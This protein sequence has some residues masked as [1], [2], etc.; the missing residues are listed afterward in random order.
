MH[1]IPSRDP[2]LH[3]GTIRNLN[4]V[5]AGGV[6]RGDRLADRVAAIGGSWGFIIAFGIALVVWTVANSLLLGRAAFDVYPYIFLNLVLS[7]LAAIQAPIIMMSQNRAAARDRAAAQLDYDINCK[8]EHEI[9]AIHERM[10]R[11]ITGLHLKL[12]A[13]LHHYGID[14]ETIDATQP[15]A[16]IGVHFSGDPA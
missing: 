2:A 12:N 10:D 8:A 6:S 13:V 9:L 11:E 15:A 1:L 7:M 5:H 4:D 14:P 16:P 3:R